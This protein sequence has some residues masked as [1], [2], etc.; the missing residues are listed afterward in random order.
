MRYFIIDLFSISRFLKYLHQE[1][2]NH[3]VHRLLIKCPESRKIQDVEF[4]VSHGTKLILKLSALYV[5]HD[6]DKRKCLTAGPVI[7]LEQTCLA[8]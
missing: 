7:L 3:I 5:L 1:S 6:T 8:G 2:N 4:T